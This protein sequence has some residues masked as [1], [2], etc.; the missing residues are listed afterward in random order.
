MNPAM[1]TYHKEIKMINLNKAKKVL[2]V[3]TVSFISLY[4][5]A[6]YA[7]E[8]C[9]Q[10]HQNCVSMDF[11][12]SQDQGNTWHNANVDRIV[13]E[14]SLSMFECSLD[15]KECIIMG[16]GG[17]NTFYVVGYRSSDYGH[18]WREVNTSPTVSCDSYNPSVY[19]YKLECDV[20]RTCCKAY[21]GCNGGG[22]F[23]INV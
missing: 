20:T 23:T 16:E 4:A 17:H 13:I 14:D 22:D 8:I 21:C 11:K 10:L 2:F 18:S 9:D 5:H 19:L 6:T 7:R 3:T 12:Y 1:K 15:V